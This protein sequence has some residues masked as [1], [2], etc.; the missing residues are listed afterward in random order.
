[1]SK[2]LPYVNTAKFVGILTVSHVWRSRHHRGGDRIQDLISGE[3]VRVSLLPHHL[4]HGLNIVRDMVLIL[5][6]M[7]LWE[8]DPHKNGKV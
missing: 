7:A 3:L 2:E 8:G 4:N 1:M 6:S 5:R